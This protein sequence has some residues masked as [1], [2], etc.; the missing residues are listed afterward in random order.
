MRPF[1]FPP[2]EKEEISHDNYPRTGSCDDNPEARLDLRTAIMWGKRLSRA[3]GFAHG[4]MRVERTE[5]PRQLGV[6]HAPSYLYELWAIRQCG[7]GLVSGCHDLGS[8]IV[9]DVV[10]S[11]YSGHFVAGCKAGSKRS[12]QQRYR[13]CITLWSL[14]C[15]SFFPRILLVF[16]TCGRTRLLS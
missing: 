2:R 11:R 12:A 1:S 8:M 13:I 16:F 15:R 5:A 10:Q 6:L 14:Q 3:E 4:T 9:G 7:P